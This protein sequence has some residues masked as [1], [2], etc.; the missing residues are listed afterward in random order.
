MKGLLLKDVY[1]LGRQVRIY[2]AL[3]VIFALLPGDSMYSFAVMYAAML[4]YTALAYDERSHWDQLARMLPCT[5][6]QLAVSKYLLG[7]LAVAAAALLSAAGGLVTGLTGG[8]DPAA[9]LLGLPAVAG[10]ALLL[11]AVT[12]PLM[13]R[14][15]V[16]RG[17]MAFLLLMMA[18]A[19]LIPLAVV[20][21]KS[22]GERFALL[23]A[24]GLPAAGL[25]AQ[26]VSVAVSARLLARGL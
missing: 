22:S 21:F 23:L 24:L 13:F 20:S 2:L 1:T 19:L 9:R 17:R 12:L 7:W 18:A 11:M 6:R 14:F 4:P 15:G 26:P 5:P 3:I 8:G 25:A 10:A 16:E